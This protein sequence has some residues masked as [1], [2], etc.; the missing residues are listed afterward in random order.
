M[1]ADAS[2]GRRRELDR[3]RERLLHF[4]DEHGFIALRL[5][6]LMAK[7]RVGGELCAAGTYVRHDSSVPRYAETCDAPH[8]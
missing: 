1:K 7:S 5:A 4:L 8:P 2:R 6:A 3:R